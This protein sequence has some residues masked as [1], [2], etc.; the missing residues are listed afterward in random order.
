MLAWLVLLLLC[1]KEQG[2]RGSLE[3]LETEK[4]M[5]NLISKYTPEYVRSRALES[6]QD[7]FATL[8]RGGYTQWGR[9]G[10]TAEAAVVLRHMR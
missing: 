7:T 6:P 1:R 3:L 9:Q 4:Q 2:R 10:T 5:C 8:V